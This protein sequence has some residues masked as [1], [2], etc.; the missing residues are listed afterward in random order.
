MVSDLTNPMTD[1]KPLQRLAP[2][3]HGLLG[4]FGAAVDQVLAA[5]AAEDSSED[6]GEGGIPK[7]SDRRL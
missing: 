2:W 3:P 4:D 7:N 1:P 5:E 6:G